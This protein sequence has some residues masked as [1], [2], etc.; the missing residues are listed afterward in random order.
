M[1]FIP[2]HLLIIAVI[3]I[4]AGICNAFVGGGS[5][6]MVP[7][8]ILFGL[9]SINALACSRTMDVASAIS[10][11]IAYRR[12]GI[13]SWENGWRYTIALMAGTLIGNLLL[14]SVPTDFLKPAVPILLLLVTA[15]FIWSPHLHDEDRQPQHSLQFITWVGFGGAGLYNGLLGP[16]AG[17]LLVAI[18]NSWAGYGLTRA[19]G[20]S[21]PLF[22]P[23]NI[24]AF[25]GFFIGGKIIWPYALAASLGV[26]IGTQLGGVFA[27]K[28]GAKLIRPFAAITSAAL[29]LRLL[30]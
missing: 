18:L 8:L 9:P 27:V 26:I 1:E 14:Q 25:I 16:G 19:V 10:N 6:I 17:V 20:E 23:A 3:G 22:I 30:L 15:Y 11:S 29:C 12:A 7:S 24:I 28:G 21:K 4:A 2:H 5:L 13:G